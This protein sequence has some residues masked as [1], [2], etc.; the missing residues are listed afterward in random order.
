MKV[1]L[2]VLLYVLGGIV[3][4]RYVSQKQQQSK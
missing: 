1:W 3:F 4:F 2:F